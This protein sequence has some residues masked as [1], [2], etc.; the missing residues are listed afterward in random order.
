MADNGAVADNGS[1]I[2]STASD[3]S[4]QSDDEAFLYPPAYLRTSL[5]RVFCKPWTLILAI[6]E[7]FGP[8]VSTRSPRCASRRIRNGKAKRDPTQGFPATD[9]ACQNTHAGRTT[10]RQGRRHNRGSQW[11]LL[12]E[13]DRFMP[14]LSV[15][16]LGPAIVRATDCLETF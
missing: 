11:T 5:M 7:R 6:R 1:Q 4:S 3:F 2:S 13:R 12:A 15:F 16:C 9:G 14:Q 10:H 8:G